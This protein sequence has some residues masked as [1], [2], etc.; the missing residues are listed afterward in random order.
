M[1]TTL[2]YLFYIA[3]III[4]YLVGKGIFEGRID[5][6]TTVGQVV[7]DVKSGAAN[8]ASDAADTAR[9][10]VNEA[11]RRNT[12]RPAPVNHAEQGAFNSTE[13]EYKM[14]ENSYNN[15]E[16]T[17]WEKTKEVSSDAWEATKD[18]SG[19]AWDKTKEVSG[20]A[21]DKTKEVSEKAWDKTKEVSGNAWD[22]TKEGAKN[23]KDKVSDSA[24]DAADA[25]DDAADEI[26]D[27]AYRAQQRN[28]ATQPE[29]RAD[30]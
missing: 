16:P 27:A 26:D 30:Y 29:N 2:K 25:A 12:V 20:N 7:D 15:G 21:W 19:K 24:D 13:G 1:G 17:T 9:E 4:V 28:S 18:A 23:L 11:G 14:T 10:V 3:L 8:M 6:K 22:K 5:E